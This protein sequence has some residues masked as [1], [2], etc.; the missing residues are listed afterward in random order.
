MAA[1]IAD[2][3]DQIGVALTAITGLRVLDFPPKSAQPP[4]AFVDLPEEIDFDAAYQRGCDRVTVSVV[5]AVADVVDRA[6]SGVN[7][8]RQA[9]DNATVGSSCRV[10]SVKFRPVTLAGGTYVGAV[11]ALDIVF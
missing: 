6:G 4:F 11:F 9:I 2:V 10:Q 7:S 3:M 8:V 1:D 5:V